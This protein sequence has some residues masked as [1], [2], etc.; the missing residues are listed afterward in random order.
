MH[1]VETVTDYQIRINRAVDYINNHLGEELDIDKLASVS[2]FSAFHFHRIISAYLNEPLWSYIIRRRIEMAA[3]LLLQTNETVNEIGY[4]IGY[5]TPASFSN[6]FKKRFGVSPAEYRNEKA[7]VVTKNYINEP[8]VEITL[9]KPKV[10][11]IDPMNIFFIQS[12]GEYGNQEMQ[13]SWEKLFAFI[14]KNKLFSL[15]MN[16]FG[17]C[18]DNPSVT[19]PTKCRYEACAKTKKEAKPEGEIGLKTIEGGK[20]AVFMHKGPYDKLGL[21]YHEIYKN[22][23]PQNKIEMRNVPSF[24]KYLN[25]P[26]HTK[27]ENLKTEI[28]IPIQ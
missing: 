12:I 27:P 17:I 14:R 13:D 16:F 6:A 11:I 7:P 18:Y 24:E 15:G 21:V 4:S 8:P 28:Y 25:N 1:R 10:K 22:W 5:E 23:I 20:Y 19:E 26:N 3:R 2:N 9:N